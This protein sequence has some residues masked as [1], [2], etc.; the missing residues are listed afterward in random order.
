M[1][2]SDLVR[3]LLTI[4]LLLVFLLS[5]FVHTGEDLGFPEGGFFYIIEQ[6]GIILCVNTNTAVSMLNALQK[7][8]TQLLS[9]SPAVNFDY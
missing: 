1:L 2:N 6:L 3:F 7:K 9:L 4:A 8:C 5:R